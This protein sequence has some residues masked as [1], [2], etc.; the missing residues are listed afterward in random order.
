MKLSYNVTTPHH[1]VDLALILV[2]VLSIRI[3]RLDTTLVLVPAEVS[4][5]SSAPH[6]WPAHASAR[7]SA[8]M[9]SGAAGHGLAEAIQSINEGAQLLATAQRHAP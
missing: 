4:G 2:R 9:G 3:L 7:P 5:A 6:H 1:D 8:S